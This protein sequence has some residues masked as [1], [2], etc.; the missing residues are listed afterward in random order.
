MVVREGGRGCRLGHRQ[1]VF[2]KRTAGELHAWKAVGHEEGRRD[3]WRKREFRCVL[4]CA[5]GEYTASGMLMLAVSTPP[6]SFSMVAA[7]GWG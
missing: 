1:G 5:S 6:V 4:T 7:D 2:S 3:E